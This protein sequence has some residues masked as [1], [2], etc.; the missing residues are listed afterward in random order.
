MDSWEIL[1]IMITKW[2]TSID[3]IKFVKEILRYCKNKPVIKTDR[4]PWYRYTTEIRIT[5]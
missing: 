1:G 5:T 4:R 2:R 3:V